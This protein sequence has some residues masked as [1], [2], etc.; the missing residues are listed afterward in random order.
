MTFKLQT[1]EIMKQGKGD[2]WIGDY[3]RD[4]VGLKQLQY[5]GIV[6]LCKYAK[7]SEF[8]LTHLKRHIMKKVF[9]IR[10]LYLLVTE[11]VMSPETLLPWLAHGAPPHSPSAQ[12]G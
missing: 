2:C 11:E 10:L 5:P 12:G 8:T 9:W 4:Q 6:V 7:M 1:S 3:C